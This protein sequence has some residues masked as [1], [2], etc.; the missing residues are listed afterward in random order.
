[1]SSPTISEQDLREDADK[2]ASTK[3]SAEDEI[4]VSGSLWRAIWQLSWP[5]Y[6]NMMIIAVAT[7]SEV[8]VGGHLGS[9]AQAAIGLGGQIWFFMIILVVALSAGTNALVS[10]FWGAGDME[11]AIIAARQSL[12][13][14]VFFGIFASVSGLLLCRPLLRALGASPEVEQLG[15]DFLKYD[16]IGQVPITIH[17]V[18]NSIFRARGDTK[19]PMY[20]MCLVVAMVVALNFILCIHPFHVGISG[21]GMSWTIASFFGLALS[22]YLQRKSVMGPCMDWNGPGMSK[23]W[24][25]RIMKIGIPACIQDLAW[26]GGNFVLL[27]ILARTANPT[28]GEA[29]WAIGLRV[30]ETLGGMPVYALSGA[31]ATLVGQNLGAKQ[32]ERA[33]DAGWKVTAVGAIYNLIVGVILFVS[34]DLVSSWMS[35]DPLV[36]K[37]SADYLRIVGVAQPFVAMWLILVGALQ[38]AGYTRWPMVVTVVALL[39]FRLPLAWYLS[40]TLGMGASGTWWSLAISGVVVGLLLA[41]QFKFCNWKAQQV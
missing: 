22:L 2:N 33:E 27:Y 1:M 9:A 18:S 16:M 30:E 20:T 11:N 28:A 3:L 8:W 14:S 6:L 26:V 23:E 39:G 19:I 34:A 25:V 10:R 12:I 17:W 36:I 21:L 13:F 4:I 15:W 29:A 7:M 31:V 41:Y 38:G 35:K 40:I 32:P 37:S 5:L 24:F